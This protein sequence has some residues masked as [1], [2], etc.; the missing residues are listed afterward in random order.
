MRSQFDDARIFRLCQ[1]IHL[2]GAACWDDGADRVLQQLREVVVQ[3]WEIESQIV[4]E[5]CD[6]KCDHAGEFVAKSIGMHCGCALYLVL[7]AWLQFKDSDYVQS[8]K[9]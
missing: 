3:R 7:C 9:H 4:F 1:R 8:S 5:G 6:G 2:D